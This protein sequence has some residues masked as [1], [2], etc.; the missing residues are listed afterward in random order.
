LGGDAGIGGA[1]SAGPPPDAAALGEQMTSATAKAASVHVLAV[2]TQG[3]SKI[4]MNVSMTRA[5][6]LSGTMSANRVAFTMLV[7]Q[8]HAYIKV[9]SA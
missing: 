1:A 7:T 5:G 2:V 9:S 8:G 4:S 6:D 3:G